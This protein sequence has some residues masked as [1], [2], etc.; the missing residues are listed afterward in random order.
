MN[1]MIAF[2]VVISKAFAI[3]WI[4][5]NLCF[6]FHNELIFFEFRTATIEASCLFFCE[7]NSFNL[8]CKKVEVQ[9]ETI[10]KSFS[11]H[12]RV[13]RAQH[14]RGNAFN[15]EK[16][17]VRECP[18]S[19]CVQTKIILNKIFGV[20]F[21]FSNRFCYY[22]SRWEMP[23]SFRAVTPRHKFHNSI[24]FNTSTIALQH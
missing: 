3:N 13:N 15:R 21:S 12:T 14:K 6:L 9:N 5:S 20:T 24:L 16:N 19:N 2:V 18:W 17:C 11:C 22:I 4:C 7:K 1:D 10:S 8:F 23:R